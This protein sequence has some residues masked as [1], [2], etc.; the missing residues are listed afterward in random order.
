MFIQVQDDL[1][2]LRTATTRGLADSSGGEGHRPVDLETL[3]MVIARTE[4]GM[5][6]VAEKVLNSAHDDIVTLPAVARRENLNEISIKS[7]HR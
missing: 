5:K 4:E 2:Y 6:A 1:Q 3:D 7:K